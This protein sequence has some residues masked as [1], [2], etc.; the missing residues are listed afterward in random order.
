MQEEARVSWAKKH[1]KQQAS[2]L[3]LS[4]LIAT[5]DTETE[6][7]G[8]EIPPKPAHLPM[9]GWMASSLQCRNCEHLRTLKPVLKHETFVDLSLT[10]PESD[11]TQSAWSPRMVSGTVASHIDVDQMPLT[12]M[13]NGMPFVRPSSPG[14]L[15]SHR[16]GGNS[17]SLQQCMKRFMKSEM[18]DDV[19]CERSVMCCCSW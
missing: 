4:G 1:E 11:G 2:K 13:D 16:N 18:I 15:L 10:L 6:E 14:S 12:T 7:E 5:H 8:Q 3:S 9:Q 17:C 19:Q